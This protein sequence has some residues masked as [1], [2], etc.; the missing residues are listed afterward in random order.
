MEHLGLTV[1]GRSQNPDKS[2][3][4]SRVI[5]G[6]YE[7]QVQGLTR[8]SLPLLVPLGRW[9]AGIELLVDCLR[10]GW[11]FG[12]PVFFPRGHVIGLELVH[13]RLLRFMTE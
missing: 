8:R 13:G 2:A 7:I 3:L 9:N 10:L 1:H 6:T 12:R 5:E 11:R 4:L